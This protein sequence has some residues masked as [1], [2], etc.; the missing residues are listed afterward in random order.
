[1]ASGD[2]DF[3]RKGEATRVR[4]LECAND[5]AGRVG[6]PGVTI[7]ALA[8]ELGLSKSGLF[9]H[10]GSKEN[11]QIAVLTY[12]AQAFQEQVFHGA[13]REARGEP[14]LRAL[15][16]NW[17]AW[18]DARERGGCVFLSS[19]M[20]WDDREGPVRAE[21]VAWFSRLQEFL[22]RAFTLA[23]SAGHISQQADVA[24]LAS[25][26]HGIVLK[27]HLDSR[28]LRGAGARARAQ[29]GFERLMQS[30]KPGEHP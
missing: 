4:I 12:A 26:F 5:I 1:V 29:A 13:L 15:L 3:E 16:T 10:F 18:I 21:L 20:D 17:L 11:L 7:G 27:Y 30:A 19:A 8:G 22:E 23:V 6:L 25:E 14:R 24:Q 9:A 28:L 2:A